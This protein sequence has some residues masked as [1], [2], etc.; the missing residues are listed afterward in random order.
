M[1]LKRTSERGT[2][3]EDLYF[4]AEELKMVLNLID[5]VNSSGEGD[6]GG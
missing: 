6:A 2:E 3:I 1:I 5:E 4:G